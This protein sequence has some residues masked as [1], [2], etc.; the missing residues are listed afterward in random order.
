MY[1][2]CW[3]RGHKL[4][5]PDDPDPYFYAK[6]GTGDFW[7]SHILR[8]DVGKDRNFVKAFL[9]FNFA[10]DGTR[11]VSDPKLRG[12]L[13]PG[14]RAWTSMASFSHLSYEECTDILTEIWEGRKSI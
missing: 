1:F 6:K 2:R 10:N 4:H 11:L 13:I 5:S 12:K 8:T 9:D 14:V 7:R 3:V